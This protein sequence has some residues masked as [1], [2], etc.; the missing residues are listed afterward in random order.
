MRM[1][2]NYSWDSDWTNA[3]KAYRTALQEFPND[4]EAMVGMGT[5]YFELKQFQSAIRALQRALG[6]NPS[7]QKALIKMSETLVEMDKPDEAAKTYIY[8]GN[9]YAKANDL[10]GAAESWAKALELN[11]DQVQARNNLAQAYARQGKNDLAIVQLIALAAI[12][13]EKG[14]DKKAT[15]YLQGAAH[16]APDNKVI[17]ASIRALENGVSI[18]AVQQDVSQISD[19][20]AEIAAKTDPE[21][22]PFSPADDPFFNLALEEEEEESGPTNPREKVK[23]HAMEELANILFEDASKFADASFSKSQIDALIGRA[24]NLQTRSDISGAINTY[25]EIIQAGFNRPSVHFILA[26]LYMQSGQQEQA[27]KYFDKSKKDQSY[28]QGINYAI[29][30]CF[31]ELNDTKQALKYFVEVLRIIDLQN[32]RRESTQELDS[33]YQELVKNYIVAGDDTKTLAFVDS[34]IKFLSSRNYEKKIIEA[35]QRLGGSNGNSV[36]TWVE[37]LE[38]PN[39]EVILSVMASSAEYIKRNMMMTAI[40]ACYRAIQ[41]S[42]AYLPLHLRLAEIYLKQE[43]LE[44]AIKKYLTVAEVYQSRSNFT[45]VTFIY[46]KVLKVAPMDV[47]V[48]LKLIDLYLDRDKI[49]SALEQYIILA[50][51]YYQ[52]AQVKNALEKYEEALQLVPKSANSKKWQ[53]TILHRMGDIYNQRVDWTN[54]TKVYQQL[55]KVSPDDANALKSLIDLFF[56]KGQS[57]EAMQ[58]LDQLMRLYAKQGKQQKIL[59]F[60]QDLTQLRPHEQALHEKL[61]SFYAYLAMNKEAI[62]QYDILGELQLEEGLRDDAARTIQK[63]IDLGPDDLT[64]YKQLLARIRG[65]I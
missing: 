58:V 47:D 41:K 6:S 50:D 3:L 11:P 14:D 17:Q 20:Q 32:A 48:R 30:E 57:T 45:Q 33:L 25:E 29:G 49:D 26:T 39:T 55:A 53:I 37:F 56:K 21:P 46:E 65:G 43:S 59:E 1:A 13:Q 63:I 2:A 10:E 7:N 27:I 12:F 24:I 54:A 5:A 22:E 61:A 52:L 23:Q 40:E 16:L 34:L 35:R 31:K 28:L 62:A 19:V 18:R 60:L 64:S 15:Q 44:K 9:L 51:S 8:S 4:A 42:P 36:S 38:A